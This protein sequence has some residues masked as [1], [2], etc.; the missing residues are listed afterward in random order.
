MI[1]GMTVLTFVHIA[2]SVLGILSGFIV[3][4]GRFAGNRMDGITAFFLVA[5]AS[6]PVFMGWSATAGRFQTRR[7][8]E[9]FRSRGWIE[10][11]IR[12]QAAG[13]GRR[14]FA[15]RRDHA[16]ALRAA[17]RFGARGSAGRSLDGSDGLGRFGLRRDGRELRPN[18]AFHRRQ[19]FRVVGIR[20]D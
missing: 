13:L 15:W 6:C 17:R 11:G 18:L 20:G 12:S 5:L 19:L 4:F 3:M 2:I 14:L 9:P 16:S 10:S 8:H 7:R 1:L